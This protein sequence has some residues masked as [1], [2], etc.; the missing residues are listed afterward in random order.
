MLTEKV[1]SDLADPKLGQVNDEGIL[2]SW[3]DSSEW[4]EGIEY[5]F[6][7]VPPRPSVNR[8][9]SAHSFCAVLAGQVLLDSTKALAFPHYV[10]ASLLPNSVLSVL[11]EK[12]ASAS[13]LP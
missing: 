5:N 6:A 9:T 11:Q 10:L 12:V 1:C 4:V 8:W 13:S 3:R 7:S 2:D